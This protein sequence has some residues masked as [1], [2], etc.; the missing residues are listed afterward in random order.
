MNSIVI[1]SVL[2]KLIIL[3]QS[4]IW[5]ENN[6]KGLFAYALVDVVKYFT[7]TID[8]ISLEDLLLDLKKAHD[9]ILL[10]WGKNNESLEELKIT[11]KQ[12]VKNQEFLQQNFA[13]LQQNFSLL[14]NKFESLQ[15]DQT[16][17]SQKQQLKQQLILDSIKGH[18]LVVFGKID[19][20][21]QTILPFLNVDAI[22]SIIKTVI[23]QNNK[24]KN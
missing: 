12:L 14:L 18:Q 5:P 8:V 4:L 6:Y 10:I 9:N 22:Q 23:D 13:I 16:L 21:Q 20:I 1:F 19:K 15:N 11:N 3:G 2:S 7:S 24:K 17:V